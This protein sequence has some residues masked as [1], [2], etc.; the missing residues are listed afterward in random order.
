MAHSLQKVVILGAGP[1]GLA[2]GHRLCANG[3]KPVV[4][5]KLHYVAGLCHTIQRDQFRFDIGGHRWFTKNDELNRWFVDLM[6]DELVKVNRISRIYFDGKYFSY[7]ISIKNVLGNAGVFTS[8]HAVMSYLL[9][10]AKGLMSDEPPLNMEDAYVK[11]FG[12]KLYEM[13]FKNY[14]EKVWG[15]SCREVSADWVEQR[16]KGLSIFTALRDA[17]AGSTGRVASLVEEFLYPRFGYGRISERMAEDIVAGGGQV[18]LKHKVLSVVHDGLK[19][20]AVKYEDSD[21]IEKTIEADA[22]VSSIPLTLLARNMTP[23][24]PDEVIMAAKKLRFR[25]LITVNVMLNREQVTKDTWLY[26]HD[27]KIPF[28][29][30]HEPKNWS[31]DMVP[32]GKTSIVAEVFCSI[33]DSMWSLSDEEVCQQVI[34]HLAHTL[35]FIKENE[36][37]GA[38]AF[39]APQA[40]PIYDLEYQTNLQLIKDFVGSIEG[41]QII[42]RGGTFRYNNSDH[43]IEMGLM[44][45]ENLLGGSFRIDSVNEAQEYLEEKRLDSVAP[46]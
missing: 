8:T 7:P 15:T 19:V 37:I 34:H 35:G 24:P 40:Y 27:S 14:S 30:L 36:V 3:I 42:G 26:I 45:A 43:S 38:F 39:R 20:V 12:R 5:E 18:L 17:L 28:A 2:A 16:T 25:D 6:R 10:Q 11:Q 32:E 1:G 23:A 33:G 46:R 4:L 22:V 21:G 41:L 29:R 31:R 9:A 13:F 44:A